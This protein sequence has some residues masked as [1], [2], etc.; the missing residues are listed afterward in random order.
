MSPTCQ[1]TT[2]VYAVAML[3]LLRH[4]ELALLVLH[5]K[6]QASL[7]TEVLL[8]HWC[9]NDIEVVMV[10][11][12]ALT[13]PRHACLHKHSMWKLHMQLSLYNELLVV[14]QPQKFLICHKLVCKLALFPGLKDNCK[15]TSFVMWDERWEAQ[16]VWKFYYNLQ[17]FYVC[18]D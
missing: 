10:H 3:R 18:H 5:H 7:L 12:Y 4:P 13:I 14:Q 6:L 1:V 11:K 9:A 17:I 2:E 15:H 16:S 8:N